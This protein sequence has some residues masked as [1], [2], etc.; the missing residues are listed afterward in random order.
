MKKQTKVLLAAA[1][2]TLGASFSSMAALKNG[3]WQLNEEGWQYANKEGDYESEVWAMSYGTEYWVNEDAVLGSSEWVEEDGHTYYVQSDGSKTKNAWKY[4]YAIDDEDE[5]EEENWYYFDSKGRMVTGKETISGSTYYFN[6]KGQMLTGWVDTTDLDAEDVTAATIGNVVYTNEDGQL[7]KSSWIN[8]FPWTMTEDDAYEDD[9]EYFY[10]T[11]NGKLAKTKT[12]ID[13]LHYFFNAETGIM[14]TGWIEKIDGVYTNTNA[15]N[16][17][18]EAYWTDEVGYAKK[19]QWLELE[20]AE[21]DD[22]E[23]WFWFDKNGKVFAPAATDANAETVDFVD[24]ESNDLDFTDI[25]GGVK[26]KKF[27]DTYYYFNQKGE[28][29]D[30]LVTINSEINYLVDGARQ[31]GKFVLEDNDL[32][33]YEFCFA[34]K[35]EDDYK[36]FKAVNGNYDGY[37]YRNGQLMTAVDTYDII[38]GF[39]VDVNG[40]IQHSKTKEYTLDNGAKFKAKDAGYEFSKVDGSQKYS[41]KEVVAE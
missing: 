25:E 10:A 16:A 29:I 17:G 23:F 36:K 38:D 15:I 21:E 14:M 6:S 28:M 41:L 3:T 39:I 35:T 34:S 32:D 26:S 27:G 7:V 31:T 24:G 13:G 4:L 12:K 22:K 19:D 30:G 2:F 40:A 9:Y 1:L 11:S 37:L 8:M 18:D 20:R 33:T 5:M